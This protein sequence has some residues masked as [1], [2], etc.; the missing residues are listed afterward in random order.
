MHA[1]Q[2]ELVTDEANS[3]VAIAAR[4]S[5]NGSR[6]DPKMRQKMNTGLKTV[7]GTVSSRASVTI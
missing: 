2:H 5:L 4:G 6:K 1:I 3:S 7:T